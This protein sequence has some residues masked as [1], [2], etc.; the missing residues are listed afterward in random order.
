MLERVRSVLV[1]LEEGSVN[2]AA[3]RLGVAQPTLSRHVQSLEQELGA[4]L[5]ERG[6][7]GM[8]PTDFGYF[9]RDKFAPILKQWDL[10]RADV[11][12]YAQGRSNQL[13]VGYIGL[14]AAKY[15]NPALA[16]LKREFPDLKLLLFDH[17]PFEQIQSLREGHLDV[18][19]VG[20]EGAAMAEDF[21]QR[22]PARLGVCV[23]LSMDHPLSSR[24]S[25]SLSEL[26]SE[27]F[28]GVSEKAAPGRN[29]WIVQLCAK[30]G[31][32]PQFIAET[33]TV[34]ETFT[35][36]ASER[37]VALLPDYVDGS[38]PPGIAYC[39]LS[40]KWA[41]WKLYVLRQRGRGSNAARRLVDLIGS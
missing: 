4:P 20:Q 10:T 33:N 3:L 34:S 25:F 13:R 23:T 37:A 26:E 11:S 21:Y 24:E 31:F 36:V 29:N 5:F 16:T 32:K 22:S 41:S 27:R 8:Q 35:L 40:D 17:T 38:P 14:A 28:V 19:I 39:R 1:V 12:A 30:A 7:K 9:L 2:R 6:P 15:L 18:A